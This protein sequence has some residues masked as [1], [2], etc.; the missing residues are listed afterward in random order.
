MGLFETV[1]TQSQAKYR[2]FKH[3]PRN[4]WFARTQATHPNNMKYLSPED[5]WKHWLYAVI[6]T[7]IFQDLGF[8]FR[9]LDGLG[10]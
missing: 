5:A 1:S 8:E 2:F 3:V 7:L 10:F 9:V 4:P 6:L